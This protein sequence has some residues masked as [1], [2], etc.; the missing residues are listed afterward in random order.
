MTSKVL[1]MTRPDD[2]LPKHCF[3]MYPQHGPVPPEP[4]RGSWLHQYSWSPVLCLGILWISPVSPT[5]P[6]L[7]RHT[8]QCSS[9][10]PFS[11]PPSSPPK[12]KKLY[13]GA[14]ILPEVKE[15]GSDPA[16]G[17][18]HPPLLVGL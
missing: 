11:V 14:H 15:W 18:R 6:T 13:P 16:Q 2:L 5:W 8:G 3:S 9:Q 17:F 7:P 10:A 1:P 12:A 4:L